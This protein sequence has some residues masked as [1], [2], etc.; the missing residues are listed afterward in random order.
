[1]IFFFEILKKNQVGA[2]SI[3]LYCCEVGQF[4]AG[5]LAH[6][7]EGGDLVE[8]LQFDACILFLKLFLRVFFLEHDFT[9]LFIKKKEA[10]STANTKRDTKPQRE[11][12]APKTQQHNNKHQEKRDRALHH[13]PNNTTCR[14][15][16]NNAKDPTREM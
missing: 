8:E 6:T 1:L 7:K 11:W 15:S 12:L 2:Y 5:A 4:H 13:E 3:V 9:C 16:C 10:E 14:T